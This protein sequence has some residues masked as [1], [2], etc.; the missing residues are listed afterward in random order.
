[1]SGEKK[2][3]RLLITN[4]VILLI[5]VVVIGV[6]MSFLYLDKLEKEFEELNS[7]TMEIAKTRI[8]MI[9]EGMQSVYYLLADDADVYTFLT[10]RFDSNQERIS[11]LVNIK[12]RVGDALVNKDGISD[13]YLYS[14]AN[15]VFIGNQA[16]LNREDYYKRYF[17]QNAYDYEVFYNIF[18][19]KRT[20]PTW[21][22]TEENLI[23]CSDVKVLG[24]SDKGKFLSGINKQEIMDVLS[25]ICGDLDMGFAVI[26]RDGEI[27]MQTEAFQQEAYEAGERKA[28]VGYRYKEY[29]VKIFSSQKSGGIKYVFTV[30]C[31][32]FGGNIAR[33]IRS[34]MLVVFAVLGMSIFFAH[35]KSLI[36]LDMYA[37]V[38]D[39]NTRLEKNLN[40]QVEKLNSQ[41]I[42]NVLRG[43]DITSLEKQYIYMKKSKI[44]VL[45]FGFADVEEL[46]QNKTGEENRA[47]VREWLETEGAEYWFLYEKDMGYICVLGYE[48]PE[49]L[50]QVIES[51]QKMFVQY[52][53]VGLCVGLSSEI[54]DIKNLPK[55]YEEAE[56][57]M[58]YGVTYGENFGV[59][60]YDDIFEFEK[61]KMYYPAEKEKQLLRNIRMG[62]YQDA[63]KCLSHIQQMNFE[64]RTLSKGA[65]RQLLIKMLNTIYELLDVVYSED[66]TKYNEFGRVS[67]NVL[68]MD[69]MEY[70]FEMIQSI[71]LSICDKCADKK[72]GELKQRIVDYIDEN[73]KDQ[74]LSME[75][76]ASDFGM[77]YYHLSRLFNEYM[78]I[79]FA[80][81]LTGVR[82]EYSKEILC[83]TSLKVEQVAI[84]SGFIQSGSFV[85]VFKKYYGV[86]P[87]KYRENVAKGNT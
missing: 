87:G 47:L 18:E 82:L 29:F 74:N 20:T 84:Q 32:R 62:M 10:K 28:G 69:N 25:E 72:E 38:L 67:R 48:L 45:I 79:N 27:L 70:A 8:D 81:Y 55:A 77:G 30:E 35:K 31:E 14:K 50:Y 9:M 71:A 36:M 4:T 16:V 86:T 59:V 12:E 78:Q 64:E 11:V 73:F 75:K 54:Y 65:M 83:N 49:E 46:E 56:A 80:T 19:E 52:Y 34:L 43:Y 6:L 3:V 22:V 33:M 37:A 58:H 53:G 5:P 26:Y 15:D 57:A 1:M 13:V 2:F 40:N 24:R 17:E 41:R 85:R 61:E 39:E 60:E 7:N 66:R 44:R 23:Y 51:L 42:M 63:E 21:F 68:L 76:M